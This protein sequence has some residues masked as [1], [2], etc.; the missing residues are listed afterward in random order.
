MSALRF[1]FARSLLS[2]VGMYKGSVLGVTGSSHS[3]CPKKQGSLGEYQH[4]PSSFNKSA[5]PSFN[6]AILLRS[7]QNG[8]LG[9]VDI[10]VIEGLLMKKDIDETRHVMIGH[11]LF[12]DLSLSDFVVLTAITNLSFRTSQKDFGIVPN[13]FCFNVVIDEPVDIFRKSLKHNI[14]GTD[15]CI[16]SFLLCHLYLLCTSSFLVQEGPPSGVASNYDNSG[17][18]PQLQ[19]TS[20]HD[21]SELGIQDHINE[22]LSSALVPNVSPSTDTDAPSLQELDLLFSPITN[23]PPTNVNVEENNT[24]QVE[25]AQFEPYEFIKPLCTLVQEVAESSSHNVDTSNMHTFYQRHPKGYKHEEGIDFKEYFAPVAH[26]EAVQIFVAYAA[27]KSFHIYQ[28]DVKM[29]FLNGPLKEELREPDADHAGCLDTRKSTSRGIQFLGDKLVNWMSKKQDCTSMSI[30]EAE[31]LMTMARKYFLELTPAD[32]IQADFDVKAINIILQGLPPEVYALVSNHRIVKEL[33]ERIQLLMQGT[34]LT[35][36]ERECKLYDEFDKFAYNKGGHYLRNSSNPRQ[37]ATINDGR[38]NL[39]PVQGRKISFATDNDLDAYDSDYDELNT[40][41]VALMVNLSHYGSDALT[42]VHNPDNVDNNMINQDPSPSCRPTKVEVPKELPKF[43]M[44]NTSLKKLKH[45]LASFNVVVKERT[46]ATAITEGSFDTQLNQ[47][48]FQR[49]NS[50]SNQSALTFDHYFELNELKA[51]S[52]EKDTV[53]KKLKERIKSLSGNINKDKVKKDIE[54]I[55]TINIELYHR[56]SKLI[57]ENEHLKQTYKQLYDSIKPTQIRSKEQCDALVSQV[58]QKSVEIFDLNVS[59]Q[60]KDLVITALKN[61]LRKLKGKDLANNVVT[62]HPIAPEMLKIDVEPIAPRLLNNG[63][64]HSDYLRHIQEQADILREIVEQG[65]LQN[66]LNNSLDSA[67]A[68]TPKNKDKRV[69]FTKP[70]TSSRNTNTKTASSSNLVSNKPMLS[71][72]RVKLVLLSASGIKQPSGQYKEVRFNKHQHSKLNANSELLCVTCNGFMLSDNHDLCVLDFINDVNART[73]SKSEKKIL[74]RK[75]VQIVLWYLDSDCSKHMVGD[76]SQLTNFVNKFLGTVKFENDHVANILGYGDYQ[77]GNV[78]ILRGINLY[79]LSPWRY[80]GFLSYMFSYQWPQGL[81]PGSMASDCLPHLNFGAINHLAKHS[82]IRGLPKLKFEKDHMCSAYAIGKAEER[83]QTKSKVNQTKEKTLSLHM[84]LVDQCVVAECYG[85]KVLLL[86]IVDDYSR[87][88]WVKC[89]RSKDEA[90]DFII[91]FLKMIQKVGISH[92][93]SVACSPQRNGVV[94][95]RNL[96]TACYTQNRSVIRLCHDKTP[97][98]LLHDKLPDL[99]FFHVFGALCYPTNDSENLGKL[100]PKAD[101]GIFIGYALTEK[102]FRIYN[103]RTRRIIEIIHVDFDELTA[104]ASEHSSSGPALHEMTPAT[105]SS[106]LVSNP[107]PSTFFDHPAPEVIAPIAKVVAPKHDALTGSPSSTTVDQDASSPSNSQT[108]LETQSPVIPNDVEEDNHD[109]DIAHMNNDLFFVEPRTIND[110]INFKHVGLQAQCKRELTMNLKPLEVWRH[111]SPQS[112]KMIVIYFKMDLQGCY[113]RHSMNDNGILREEVYV[114]QP[115]GFVDQDNPNHVYKLKK[116]LYGL[117]QAPRAWY[118]LLSK[119]L[120]SQ[121]FSK[122]TVDPTLFI[123]RQGKDILMISQSPR[124]I[125]INQS[126]YALESLKKYGMESCYPMDTPMVEKSKLDEDTQGKAVNPTHYC[127]MV[128]TLMYLTAS[129]PYLTFDVCMCVRYQAKPTEKHLHAIKRIF[130][131]LRGTVNR[132]LWY[133]KD[134]SIAL[135]AYADADQAGCQD[136]RR[137]T[138]GTLSGCCAQVLW[139]RSQLTD[140]GLGFNKI[141]MY[142]DNKSDITLCFNN[143]QHSRSKHIDIIFHFIKEQVEN[144][145]VELYFVNTEYQLADIFTKA[146]GREK[147][148]FLST[149]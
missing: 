24:D 4:C 37:Q 42:E 131:Y 72:T 128:G 106:G 46:M 119:F 35:K 107:P 55:E 80:D 92:E 141:P 67:L 40:A 48:I 12:V 102:A 134:S 91:K 146:L 82:L 101:I 77:I 130:K 125:F 61:E 32:A 73:K 16:I 94:E 44:E 10:V 78:T 7:S 99:S 68:V 39:Q 63:T 100:L 52:Q 29:D 53:I 86:I 110:D 88:T 96:A 129:R 124:G 79:T 2:F 126:K 95:R 1:Q 143:V 6:N 25:D 9:T 127:G 45:H 145:V 85:K 54:E 57:T 5:I 31:S 112:S 135:T 90:P 132:G 36:Q 117:K 109:L 22:P 121:E 123:R 59:L 138:S 111:L 58:N 105:I 76:R 28:M 66:L 93:T 3:F 120:L 8:L 87:F 13:C 84:D 74:K 104:M 70:V 51:Q 71:S 148:N 38:V 34:S 83:H 69:R 64:A 147:L 56:V 97:Y 113:P 114:S 18:E 65:K 81:S 118:D 60:E 47:E 15:I 98:E 142:Y 50:V 108:T 133:P 49:D 75:V 115:D 122:G 103:R 23:T 116:A 11:E 89:L 137:S 14:G 26:L 136:T 43:S 62:K 139:I 144:G 27:Y 149:S 30:A 33:W 21:R 20:D 140:Y 19:V 17:P 41:K